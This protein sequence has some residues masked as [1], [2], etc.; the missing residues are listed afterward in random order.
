M[1]DKLTRLQE[2]LLN[3]GYKQDANRIGSILEEYSNE[4]QLSELSARKLIAMCNPKYFG[5]FYIRE[6]D[7]TYK[8][9]NFLSEVVSN[10]R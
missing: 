7:D 2:Y 5:N 1:K 6:F 9:W 8:W 4:N 10:I 3:N